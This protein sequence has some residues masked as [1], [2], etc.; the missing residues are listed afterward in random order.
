[1]QSV[2][3]KR[4]AQRMNKV[5]CSRWFAWGGLRAKDAMPEHQAPGGTKHW[6]Q[7]T[8]PALM[9]DLHAHAFPEKRS[10]K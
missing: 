10:E 1:M 8:V 2:R 3:I 9:S 6:T 4:A 7:D 5:V